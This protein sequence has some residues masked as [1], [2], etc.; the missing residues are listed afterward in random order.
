MRFYQ[1]IDD[2]QIREIIKHIRTTEFNTLEFIEQMK[3]DQ[4]EIVLS[5]KSKYKRWRPLVG[6]ILKRFSLSSHEIMHASPKK[7]SPAVW[8]KA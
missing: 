2:K 6:K 5:L 4:P 3:L 1:Y 8:R 7:I